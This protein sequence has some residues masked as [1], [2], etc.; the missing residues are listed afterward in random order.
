MKM[1]VLSRLLRLIDTLNRKLGWV[2]AF[3]L[4]PMAAIVIW[5][6]LM[7]YLFNKPSL[8][9]YE[10]SLFIYGGY[11]VLTGAYTLLNKGHVNV[12]LIYGSRS[13]RV[14]AIMDVCTA[15]LFFIFMWF[16]LSYSLAQT[17]T[18]WQIGE[19]TNTF[20]H[21]IYYP[22]R[23]T[24]PVACILMMLQGGAKLIRDFYLALTGKELPNE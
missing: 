8:W 6:V 20:W 16:L 7:R 14:K 5:D 3:M 9:A 2:F 21:P 13:P 23:T 11:I 22:L 10:T 12:D 18:S 17:I 1:K 19:T 24:L 4:V 15:G